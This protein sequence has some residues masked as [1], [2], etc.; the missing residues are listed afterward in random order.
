MTDGLLDPLTLREQEILQLL[1]DGLT[2]QELGERLFLS[3]GTVKWHIK[4]I[5]SKFGMH[6]R[7]AV[8]ARARLL[9][10]LIPLLT[11][12]L[13]SMAAPKHN[14]P[15][16]TTS[17]VGRETDMSSILALLAD[18]KCRLITLVGMGGIGKTRLAIQCAGQLIDSF[19]DGVF[20]IN[21]DSVS[22][23]F[24]PSAIA[25]VLNFRTAGKDDLWVQLIRLLRYKKL[26]LIL[27][28]FEHLAGE[29]VFVAQALNAAP[30]LKIIVTSR[31]V[32]NLA[33]EWVYP[34]EG[35][36]VPGEMDANHIELFGAANLFIDRATRV[37]KDFSAASEA[38]WIA[39]ICQLVGGMP[40]A[41]E[42]L[43]T[44]LNVLNCETI[45]RELEHNRDM[46][47]AERRD[48]PP[49]QQSIQAVF[50]Q[51]WDLLDIEEQQVL[52]KIAVFRGGFTRE[53]AHQVA[54]ASL[55]T[56]LALVNKSL[57]SANKEGRHG[58]HLLLRHFL[59]AKLDALA[60]LN[61]QTRLLHSQYYWLRLQ[62]GESL[63]QDAD[64][65]WTGMAYA[66]EQRQINN[67]VGYVHGLW[68]HF[69]SHGW[70]LVGQSIFKLYQDSIRVIEDETK[71]NPSLDVDQGTQ[72]ELYESLANLLHTAQ[73]FTEARTAYEAAL[74]HSQSDNNVTQARLHRKIG[75][76]YAAQRE[77]VET[78]V[79]L[80]KTAETTLGPAPPESELMWWQEWIQIQLELAWGY[81]SLHD[82][83]AML[84]SMNQIEDVV[85]RIGTSVQRGKLHYNHTLI[86]LRRYGFHHLP[87][88]TL[89]HAKTSLEAAK[90]AG[91]YQE[92]SWLDFCVAFVHLWRD[93]MDEAEAWFLRTLKDGQEFGDAMAAQITALTYLPLIY[94]RRQDVE[95]T[96][97]WAQLGLQRATEAQIPFYIGTSLANIG[98]VFYRRGAFDEAKTYCDK[99]LDTWSQI[100]VLIPMQWFARIPLLAIAL[101]SGAIEQAIEHARQLL[102]PKQKILHDPLPALLS[103][104]IQ[105]WDTQDIDKAFHALGVF[106]DACPALGYL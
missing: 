75:L 5:Y 27:D 97:H 40:L 55:R 3:V 90:Q 91:N 70:Y 67:I 81:Y 14:L 47:A 72:R 80:Y 13:P 26:L 106:C 44:W 62:A 89:Y 19:T 63:G 11:D 77:Y 32:L 7:T 34:V 85:Q 64:N 101:Q 20:Y 4:N 50:A 38:L 65:V 99:A 12:Q 22:V 25:N 87:D 71:A 86:D 33:E 39:Q 105:A 60:V 51:S 10:L 48:L 95:V 83:D 78:M 98:W 56:L 6:K 59:E 68:Q 58:L 2:D 94:R 46:I 76:T 52:M 88:E 30:G 49:R 29:A 102:N 45:A 9:G 36:G 15:Y 103:E 79:G 82:I 73:R 96:E 74:A 61:N 21:F 66:I 92:V 93:E 54:G 100:V 69:E 57:I 24:V 104:A 42:L 28:S 37:R 43:T 53:A 35:L 41:I 8:V 84:R 1:A 18:P 23:S 31:E 17:F 16:Q